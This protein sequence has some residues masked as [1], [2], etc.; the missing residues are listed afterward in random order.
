MRQA[1]WCQCSRGKPGRVEKA[2]DDSHPE[3]WAVVREDGG[4]ATATKLPGG[5]LVY[6]QGKSD[7]TYT[8]R[9]SGKQLEIAVLDLSESLENILARVDGIAVRIKALLSAAREGR[10]AA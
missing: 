4:Y 2:G 5:L 3:S 10:R 6:A 8:V 7:Q 1:N 9:N